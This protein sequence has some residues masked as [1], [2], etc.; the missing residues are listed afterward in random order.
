[1]TERID[2]GTVLDRPLTELHEPAVLQRLEEVATAYNC[3]PDDVRWIPSL[4]EP[5]IHEFVIGE[6]KGRPHHVGIDLTGRSFT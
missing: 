2:E 5:E 6:K 1:M 3:W 4:S